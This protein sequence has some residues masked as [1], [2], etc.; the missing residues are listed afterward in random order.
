MIEL[1]T[2]AVTV[3]FHVLAD[4]ESAASVMAQTAA[5]EATRESFLT[6]FHRV[7]SAKEIP[8]HPMRRKSDAQELLRLQ[9]NSNLPARQEKH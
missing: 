7:E 2:F 6:R 5:C 9:I 4:H 1:K 8:P 3:T